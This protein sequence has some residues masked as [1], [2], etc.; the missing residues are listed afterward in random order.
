[1]DNLVSTK[2]NFFSRSVLST[3]TDSSSLS[4]FYQMYFRGTGNATEDLNPQ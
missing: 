1:M 4:Y 3:G 2:F